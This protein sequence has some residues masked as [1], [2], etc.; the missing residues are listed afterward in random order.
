MLGQFIALTYS[1]SRYYWFAF[2]LP[3]TWRPEVRKVLIHN[4]L[5]KPVVQ[6][7]IIKYAHNYQGLSQFM[8]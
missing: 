6:D 5:I 3:E 4:G 1:P 7:I 8:H 2:A